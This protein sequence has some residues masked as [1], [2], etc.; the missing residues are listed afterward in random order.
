MGPCSLFTDGLHI[1]QSTPCKQAEIGLITSGEREE[2]E[3]KLRSG[4][5]KRFVLVAQ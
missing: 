5:V 3:G 2:R 1:S 4:E